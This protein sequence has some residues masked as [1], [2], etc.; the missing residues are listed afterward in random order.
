MF[1]V[2]EFVSSAGCG[3]GSLLR[4]TGFSCYSPVSDLVGSLGRHLGG[5]G[6]GLQYYRAR[7]SYVLIL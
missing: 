6:G 4:R 1:L 2:A 3:C 5:S 7:I